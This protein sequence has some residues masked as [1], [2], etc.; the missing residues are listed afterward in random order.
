MATAKLLN[1]IQGL[2][3]AEGEEAFVS[4]VYNDFKDRLK[5]APPAKDRGEREAADGTGGEGGGGA[6]KRARGRTR[7]AAKAAKGGEV[8]SANFKTMKPT[9]VPDL[10]LKKLKAFMEPYDPQNHAD[11]TVL[12]VYFLKE[13]L[14]KDPCTASEIFT[15]YRML[16]EKAPVA[17]GQ[18]LIDTRGKKS[19]IAYTNANDISITTVGTNHVEHDLPK[20]KVEAA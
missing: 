15:C 12:F 11:R 16:K 5:A 2:I 20:K 8:G 9:L 6:R 4:K 3:E 10:D 7:A 13:E 14:K 17:F 18:H 1:L 19:F